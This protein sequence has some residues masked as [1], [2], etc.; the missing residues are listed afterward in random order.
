MPASDSELTVPSV[1]RVVKAIA[2]W[3][4]EVAAAML[5]CKRARNERRVVAAKPKGIIKCNAHCL[6][7]GNV[8]R[9]IEIAFFAWIFEV[10]GRRNDRVPDGQSAG[11]HLYSTGAA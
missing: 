7:A 2:V 4:S 6:F 11:G 5:I 3:Q 10:D 9:V 1:E 8:G